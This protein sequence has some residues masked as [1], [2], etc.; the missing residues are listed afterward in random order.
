MQRSVPIF[1]A[2]IATFNYL[3]AH[4][5]ASPDSWP[6]PIHGQV[7]STQYVD[8]AWKTAEQSQVL[9]LMPQAEVRK[10]ALLYEWLANINEIERARYDAMAQVRKK[11]IANPDPSHFSPS[12]IDQEI[13]SLSNL[14]LLCAKITNQQGGLHLKFP[15]FRLA[16]ADM[17]E[18]VLHW[19]SLKSDDAGMIKRRDQIQ[20]LEA[21]ADDPTSK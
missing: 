4:P 12:Q 13:E 1:T 7:A 21:E 19:P 2:D 15:E 8:S 3:K 6:S 14:I 9:E 11:F 18:Q 10:D 20:K 17:Y 5:G 16:P